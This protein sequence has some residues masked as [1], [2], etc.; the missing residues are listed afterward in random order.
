LKLEKFC[1][2]WPGE[3]ILGF[4]IKNYIGGYEGQTELKFHRNVLYLKRNLEKIGRFKN[5]TKVGHQE[6]RNGP[7]ISLIWT[8]SGN[9]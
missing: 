5:S 6:A 3:A 9:R 8:L 1:Q 4:L 2:G 7:R